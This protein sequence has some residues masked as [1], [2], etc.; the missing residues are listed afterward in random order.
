[1]LKYKNLSYKALSTLQCFI[2]LKI[3][4]HT[5]YAPKHRQIY[6]KLVP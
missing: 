5:K 3:S 6:S 1:M 2:M 4:I